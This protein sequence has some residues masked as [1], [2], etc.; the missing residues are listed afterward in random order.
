MKAYKLLM[1]ALSLM[2]GIGI[3]MA[4]DSNSEDNLTMS[5]IH[6]PDAML[7]GVVTTP[8]ALPAS[9]S[10]DAAAGDQDGGLATANQARMRRL[11]GLATAMSA[12]ESAASAA[13]NRASAT[14]DEHP[15]KPE[16]PAPPPP[17][18]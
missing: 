16:T 15:G 18:Q 7:P 10:T 3:A 11:D 6:N 9:A 13:D 2:L 8:I 14:R 5:V 12:V 4:Q 17:G 1:I